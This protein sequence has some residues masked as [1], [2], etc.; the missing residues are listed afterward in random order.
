MRWAPGL[1]ARAAAPAAPRD[2]W[3]T[4]PELESERDPFDLHA[5][6]AGF[7]RDAVLTPQRQLQPLHVL[8]PRA[9]RGTTAPV[10]R[11]P[12]VIPLARE[13]FRQQHAAA[14]RELREWNGALTPGAVHR[15]R[16]R[17]AGAVILHQ[18]DMQRLPGAEAMHSQT[19]V[20][21]GGDG[22][23]SRLDPRFDHE[24]RRIIGGTPAARID[25][26]LEV[27]DRLAGRRRQRHAT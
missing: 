1:A 15:Y 5:V 6:T 12:P 18:R 23:L 14:C 21:R 24:R 20:L 13:S 4:A 19:H 25:R 10:R 9:V 11:S 7:G 2:R 22:F 3:P 8:E 17:P 26:Q 16:R 27:E